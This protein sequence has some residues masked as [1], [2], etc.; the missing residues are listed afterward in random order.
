VAALPVLTSRSLAIGEPLGPLPVR[1]DAEAISAAFPPP[2]ELDREAFLDPAMLAGNH[3]GLIFSR[4]R[5]DRAV[6]T[7]SDIAWVRRIRIGEALHVRGALAEIV[8]RK[9]RIFLVFATETL[10]AA[11]QVVSRERTELMVQE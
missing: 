6:H 7:G 4:F 8:R 5:L 10:D 2:G 9:E 11:G 1:Y 3:L